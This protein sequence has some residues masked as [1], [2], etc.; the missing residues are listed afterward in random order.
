MARHI[1]PPCS[2]RRRC[3]RRLARTTA[4]ALALQAHPLVA[5]PDTHAHDAR[6]EGAPRL[7]TVAFPTSG[8]ALAQAS[9]LRGIAF[10]HSFHYEEAAKAFQAAERADTAFAL[11]YWFEAFTHSHPLWGEDDPKAARQVLTRLGPTPQA[12][13]ERAATPRERAYGAAIEAFFADTSME[14]RAR[15]FADSMRS[16]TSL[17]PDDLE[18][19]RCLVDHAVRDPIDLDGSAQ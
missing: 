11:P 2:I 14:V 17:Y 5:Q 1:D 18:A 9:F 3:V 6:G 16:L 19:A 8:N 15:A 7:G 10:L 4:L 12:R 13:L